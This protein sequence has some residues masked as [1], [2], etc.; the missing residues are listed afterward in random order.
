MLEAYEIGISLALQDGV[1]AGI[2]LIRRDLDALD[3]AIAA[4]SQNLV[5]LQAQ[6]GRSPIFSSLGVLNAPASPETAAGAGHRHPAGATFKPARHL[7]GPR[8]HDLSAC[9]GSHRRLCSPPPPN[10][11]K[12]QAEPSQV[13][14]ASNGPRL[15][16]PPSETASPAPTSTNPVARRQCSRHGQQADRPRAGT[17]L[18]EPATPR[19]TTE[20]I[21]TH[22]HPAQPAFV[23]PGSNSA[24]IAHGD[25]TPHAGPPRPPSVWSRPHDRPSSASDAPSFA[26]ATS[27][28]TPAPRL[29]PKLD[30]PATRTSIILR[31][32]PAEAHCASAISTPITAHEPRIAVQSPQPRTG[33]KLTRKGRPARS[34]ARAPSLTQP[35]QVPGP[36]V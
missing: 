7:A 25:P 13:R 9:T 30:P 26:G 16:A 21:G 32:A 27:D 1:S 2:A 17:G 6:A 36:P 12:G 29:P 10:S 20:T 14:L 3:R 19:P 31:Q 24:A 11:T 8:G 4:T 18:S 34:F 35:Q 15:P 28:P 5:S 23:L 33:P 22:S